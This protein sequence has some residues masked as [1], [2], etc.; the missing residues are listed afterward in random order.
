MK[1]PAIS[2]CNIGF[3]TCL[4]YLGRSN[5]NRNNPICVASPKV[6]K[7]STICV[8]VTGI[9]VGVIVLTFDN[10]NTALDSKAHLA[11]EVKAYEIGLEV[12]V[13]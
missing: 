7:A 4:G 12:Q 6:T 1:M 10:G 3:L 8:A 2:L 5:I 11:K 9:I 13:G